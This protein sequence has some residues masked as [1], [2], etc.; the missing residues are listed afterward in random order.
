MNPNEPAAPLPAGSNGEPPAAHPTEIQAQLQARLE[1]A[2]VHARAGHDEPALAALRAL[3][4]HI[5]QLGAAADAAALQLQGH[6]LATRGE[7][8]IRRAQYAAALQALLRAAPQLARPGGERDRLYAFSAMAF[9]YLNL[10]LPEQG[11][12]AARAGHAL[13]RQHG[14][15]PAQATALATVGMCCGLLGDPVAAEGH[16]LEALGLLRHESDAGALAMCLNNLVHFG[17]QQADHFLAQGDP[18]RA[19]DALRRITRHLSAGARIEWVEGSHPHTMWRSNRAGWLRRQG[20]LSEAEPELQAVRQA[21]AANGWIVTER[22]ATLNLAELALARGDAAAASRLF[23][24]TLSV[25]DAPDG[26][27]MLD[28]AHERLAELARARGDAAAA[29]RHETALAALAT[30]RTLQRS[31][32]L[33]RLQELDAVVLQAVG[34]EHTGRIEAELRRLR[35]AR[36]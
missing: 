35:E 34:A 9:C 2:R 20:R 33:E 18:A 4:E 5:S 3:I 6:A 31:A 25:G 23:E 29:G 12:R 26:F 24:S 10:G 27:E 7:V 1:A 32:A 8:L 19:E 22:E 36:T 13:A 15:V 17:N 14:V 28:R 16:G 11:L 21:A 30:A